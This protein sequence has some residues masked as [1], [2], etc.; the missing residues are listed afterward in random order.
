ML[1]ELQTNM[2]LLRNPF[3]DDFVVS[4]KSINIFFCDS[5]VLCLEIPLLTAQNI[6]HHLYFLLF[7]AFYCHANNI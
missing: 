6:N 3:K 7:L 4:G 1:Y 2:Q 5:L